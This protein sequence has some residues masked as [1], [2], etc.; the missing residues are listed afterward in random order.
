MAS[1]ITKWL[2]VALLTFGA[3]S[4]VASVGK[5]RQPLTGGVAA[6]TVLSSGAI[7]AA[8]LIFWGA[9]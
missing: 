1:E 7:I 6:F 5:P 8:I 3:L 9:R 4:T 2:I